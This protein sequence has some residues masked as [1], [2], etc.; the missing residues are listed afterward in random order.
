MS[1]ALERAIAKDE[2]NSRWLRA[3]AGISLLYVVVVV[4]YLLFQ[5]FAIQAQNKSTLEDLKRDNANN[6]ER[7]QQFVRCIADALAIPIEIRSSENLDICTQSA[8]DNTQ[9][10]SNPDN[11]PTTPQP[12]SAAP[13]TTERQASRDTPTLSAPPDPDEEPNLIQVITKPLEMILGGL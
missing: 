7:T 12:Q 6:H 1:E 5:S 8:S 10:S 13:Q 3:S 2:R 4:T 11:T 9:D